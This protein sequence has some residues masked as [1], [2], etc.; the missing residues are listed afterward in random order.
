MTFKHSIWS[1]WPISNWDLLHMNW[2]RQLLLCWK[3]YTV[4]DSIMMNFLCSVTVYPTQRLGT[5]EWKFHERTSTRQSDTTLWFSERVLRNISA[6]N[7]PCMSQSGRSRGMTSNLH[8]WEPEFPLQNLSD[9][10]TPIA[11]L[12]FCHPLFRRSST[13]PSLT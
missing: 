2:Q 7:R 6:M 9:L 3:S 13:Y 4:G 8:C 11:I 1:P 12:S 10:F 5:S